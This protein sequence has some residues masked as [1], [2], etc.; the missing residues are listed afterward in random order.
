MEQAT[1]VRR[2]V[3]EQGL[4]RET[5]ENVVPLARRESALGGSYTPVELSHEEL[6]LLAEIATGVTTEVAARHLELSA[7]TLRRRIRNICDVLGVNTP[8]EAV[9]WAARR[10]LI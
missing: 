5:R 8:I 10:Q 2:T 7:R 4:T 6:E 1:L 3:E 9:V